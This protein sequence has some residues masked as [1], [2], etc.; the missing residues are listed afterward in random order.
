[1][2]EHLYGFYLPKH[3]KFRGTFNGLCILLLLLLLLVFH[4]VGIF[5]SPFLMNSS[6]FPSQKWSLKG[7]VYHRVN[8]VESSRRRTSETIVNSLNYN[9][10]ENGLLQSNLNAIGSPSAC[11]GLYKHEGYSTKCEY[12]RAN[13]ECSSGGFFNYLMF[14]YCDCE[15]FSFLGFVALVIWLA[16]LFYMLGNTAADYFCCLL[17]KLSDILKFR[18]TVA[19]VTL[20]PLGNGAPDVFASIVAFLGSGSGEVGLN[21]VLGAA[22]F[23]TCVVVGTVSFCVAKLDVQIDKKCFIRDVCFFLL[24]LI[25]LLVI[26]IVGKVSIGGA[27]AFVSI[28]VVYG[29]CV[30][31][32]EILQKH[33][34]RLD[35]DSLVPLLPVTMYSLEDEKD[36]SVDSDYTDGVPHLQAKLPHWMW[37]ADVAIYSNEAVK[38]NLIDRPEPLWGWN[39]EEMVNNHS[40]FCC[41]KVLFSCS[42]LCALLKLP[43]TLPRQLTIPVVE[44]E[45]WSKGYAV[46]SA[47]LAP[48]LLALLW[49]T[50]DNVGSLSGGIACFVGAIVGSTFG[51]LAFIYTRANRPP[52]RFLFLWVLGGF[53]MSIIWFY[54]IANELVALLVALGVIL[55]IKASLLGLTVMAW[56]N[57]T[58][59]IVSNVAMAMTGGD[60]VQIAMSGCYAGPMFITLIG[61]GISMLLGALST[62]PASFIV[63]G[64]TGLY[65]TMGFLVCGLVWSL[66]VLPRN[67]MRP[68]KLLGIGLITIYFIF[69]SIRI[70]IAIGGWSL[71]NLS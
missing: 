42:K 54:I 64:D 14:F 66:I 39:D 71:E 15:N 26:L 37:A 8:P 55:E 59:D 47:S 21:S 35:S 34:P 12:L 65:Y 5:K 63:P 3:S 58:G 19:G 52:R 70:S 16:S 60:G 17:E 13:R 32:N 4:Q 57:S 48:M 49:N 29:F 36:E 1:M 18:P 24:A 22:L 23:V 7:R 33:A 50:R 38:A 46:A 2:M 45:R 43:L 51:L 9:L 31:G 56:G 6:L 61:L 67:N 44:E 62:R 28:Y 40:S 41:R 20:L 30:A 10:E 27:V 69:L 68:G 25:S 11:T 53:F